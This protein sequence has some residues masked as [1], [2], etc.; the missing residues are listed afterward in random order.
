M[1]E[2]KE[3]FGHYLR[4]HTVV[5]VTET[6]PYTITVRRYCEIIKEPCNALLEFFRLN[7]HKPC[8]KEYVFAGDNA[9]RIFK[10]RCEE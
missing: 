4:T 2:F 7:K 8:T 10:G 6:E 9:E 1:S 3:V 5:T